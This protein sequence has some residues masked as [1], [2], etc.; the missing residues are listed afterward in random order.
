MAIVR[1]SS[2]KVNIHIVSFD[3]RSYSTPYASRNG[4]PPD[5][6][7]KVVLRRQDRKTTRVYLSKINDTE[8]TRW[9]DILH[10]KRVTI[11]TTWNI[12]AFEIIH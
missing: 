11:T 12:E 6:A 3:L 7:S 8:A 9:M 4:V 5:V 2:E 1:R 10:R